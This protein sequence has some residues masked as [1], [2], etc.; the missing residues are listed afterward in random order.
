M[1]LGLHKI[2]RFGGVVAVHGLGHRSTLWGDRR[3]DSLSSF[4]HSDFT[5]L[6]A[7]TPLG[8]S[9]NIFRRA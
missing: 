7:E 2:A 3:F 6:R 8:G 5:G 1:W 9:S 4:V